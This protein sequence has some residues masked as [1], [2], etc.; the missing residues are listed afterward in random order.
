MIDIH[1]HILPGVDD[2]AQTIEESIQMAEAA[3]ADGIDT[4]IATPHHKNGVYNNFKHD[5]ILQVG[6]LNRQLKDKNIPLTVLPGQETRVYG[7][8]IEGLERNEVLTL[9]EDTNYVFVEFP[10]AS[11][12]RYV[13]QL[14]F[15]I[16]LAG[17]QPVI[18]HPERNK[19]IMENPDVLYSLVK[20]GAFTQVTAGS[21]CGH[22]GKKIKKF[23]HQ[24]LEHNLAHLVAS[25]AHNTSKRG[26]CM[27]EAYSHIR[28]TF[29]LDMVYLLSENA[30]DVVAGRV[31]AAEPPE[32]IQQK[33]LFGL[34]RK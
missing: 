17:Y 12:P 15:D 20:K 32:H 25:D 29:G 6:E 23:S 27:T 31:L 11:V 9:N 30:E 21:V 18:V 22:F 8:F 7:E 14:L 3:V 34:F 33:K 4:I 13:S 19:Q 5:I 28:R 26:F 10:S 24:L 1:S 16:Q 2:G